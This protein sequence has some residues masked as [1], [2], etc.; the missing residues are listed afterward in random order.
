[1]QRVFR[2]KG[3]LV[4]I[5]DNDIKDLFA[6]TDEG[7]P[8]DMLTGIIQS[9]LLSQYVFSK[10]RFDNAKDTQALITA[11]QEAHNALVNVLEYKMRQRLDEFIIEKLTETITT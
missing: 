8:E 9:S 2:V 6:T 10:V 1:M 5:D 11:S 7:Y 3:E 4:E